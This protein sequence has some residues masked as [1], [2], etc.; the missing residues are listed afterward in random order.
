MMKNKHEC[1]RILQ[2]VIESWK[3]GYKVKQSLPNAKDN[4]KDF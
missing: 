1:V 3:P 4:E 2:N